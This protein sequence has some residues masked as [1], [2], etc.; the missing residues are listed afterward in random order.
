MGKYDNEE[1]LKKYDELNIYIINNRLFNFSEVLK[2]ISALNYF[3]KFFNIKDYD[4]DIY[5]EYLQQKIIINMPPNNEKIRIYG[6]DSANLSFDYYTDLLDYYIPLIFKNN[7]YL[8][9]NNINTIFEYNRSINIYGEDRKKNNI[10]Y[11]IS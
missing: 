5:H 1:I 10:I 11:N 6:E 3:Y 4:N 9:D 2:N 7:K 8:H